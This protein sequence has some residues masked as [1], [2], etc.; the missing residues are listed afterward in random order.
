[1]RVSDLGG[2]EIEAGVKI[3][4]LA[5]AVQDAVDPG[6]ISADQ[7]IGM[8]FVKKRPVHPRATSASV[9]SPAKSPPG[10]AAVWVQVE[11][12]AK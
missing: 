1:L 4:K 8:R 2:G 10:R 7:S 12:A 11:R 9:P 3:L 6:G 5:G